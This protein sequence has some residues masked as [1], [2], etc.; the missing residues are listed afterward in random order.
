MSNSGQKKAVIVEDVN[1]RKG[2]GI[3][4]QTDFSLIKS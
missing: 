4:H 1:S 3:Q 2:I